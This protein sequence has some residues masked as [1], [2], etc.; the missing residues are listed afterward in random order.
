MKGKTN[1]SC[2]FYGVF[3][4]PHAEATW[5]LSDKFGKQLVNYANISI[6]M[7]P[8]PHVGN[9]EFVPKSIIMQGRYCEIS[10]KTAFLYIL[11]DY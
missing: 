8:F 6:I 1:T 7:E 4:P 2:L 9:T 3:F 10:D 5:N 11:Q